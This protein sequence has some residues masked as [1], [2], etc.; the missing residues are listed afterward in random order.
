MEDAGEEIISKAVDLI[1]TPEFTK[2]ATAMDSAT[3]DAAQEAVNAAN[4][5]TL[6]DETV[7]TEQFKTWYQALPPAMKA[8]VRRG[9]VEWLIGEMETGR[10]GENTAKE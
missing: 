5:H 9:F 1:R 10:V 8:V 4:I 3:N 6:H 7:K 2:L